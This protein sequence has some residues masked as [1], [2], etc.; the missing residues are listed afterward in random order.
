MSTTRDYY[1]ILGLSKDATES[2]IKKAYRKLAMQYHPDKNKDDDAEEKF[3]EISEAY[4]VLSDTE[5]REQYDRFG[6]AG[7]DGRYSQEDI[8]RNADFGGFED[9]GDIFGSIFGGGFGGFGGFGGGQRRQGPSRGSDLRYD[10]SITLEQAA[11]GVDTTINVPRAENCETCSGT[12]A[13]AGTTPKVCSTCR[14]SGQ[15]TQARNTPFGR[16]MSTSTCNACHGQGEIIEEPCP[17]CKGTGKIKKVR[18]ISVKVPKGADNGIRL[19]IRGEGEEGSP[20]APSGDLYVVIHVEPHDKFQRIG[21]DILYEQPISFS[22]AALGGD[23]M[24]PTLHG[25][26]KMNIKAGTQTHSILRLKGKG[27]PHLHGHS[28][29]DQ[30]VKLIVKTPTKLTGE[31]KE[32][33]QKFQQLEGGADIKNP[34]GG[35]GIFGKMKGAFEAGI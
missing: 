1:E 34:K 21:N 32:L 35:K 19:K 12:G 29:G 13:K 3:K 16:F 15:V 5:K 17:A 9:L 18:K 8:F 30:L 22:M 11:T 31:Q 7:I 23:V 26:V 6:H 25:K 24:V 20:G 10:L 2:E 4:A 28:H 27:M 14:G 33:L